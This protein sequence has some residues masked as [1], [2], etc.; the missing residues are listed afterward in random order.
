MCVLQLGL[1]VANS[2]GSDMDNAS[3]EMSHRLLSSGAKFCPWKHSMRLFASWIS[4]SIPR[5]IT[6]GVTTWEM[7]TTA[8]PFLRLKAGWLEGKMDLRD[9]V[10]ELLVAY[11]GAEDK[12]T[13]GGVRLNHWVAS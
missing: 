5:F 9:K 11:A 12:Q 13:V 3:P 7:S 6:R 2:K 10:F 4:T 8:G 1:E